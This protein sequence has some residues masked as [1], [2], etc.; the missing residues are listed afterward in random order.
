MIYA[1]CRV[2]TSHKTEENQRFVIEQFAKE[3]D[4]LI[5]VWVEE[6]VSSG[7]KIVNAKTWHI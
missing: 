1:Y 6:I 4:I 2:S 3:N 5:D 7:K